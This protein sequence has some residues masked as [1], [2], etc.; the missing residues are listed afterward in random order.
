MVVLIILPGVL[1]APGIS[2]AGFDPVEVDARTVAWPTI[3]R[4]ALEAG[5]FPPVYQPVTEGELADLLAG[6]MDEAMSGQAE[7]FADNA[8][9]ARLEFWLDRYLRG[10]GGRSWHGCDC[11]VHPPQVRLTG[12]ALAGFT[13]LGTTFDREAGLGWSPGW[14][15]TLE[16]ALDFSAGP[17]WISV[18]GRL[19]GQ[20]APAGVDFSGAGGD[21]S[22]LTWPDWSIPTGKNQVRAARLQG[23]SWSLEAPRAVAGVTL[24]HWSLSAGWAPR[25]TGPGLTGALAFDRSGASIPAVTARRTRKFIWGSRFLNFFAPDELLLTTGVLSERLV[26]YQD[27]EEQLYE[28]TAHPWFFQWLIGWRVTPWFRA[29]FTHAAM[30]APREGT[31]WGDVLQINFPIKGTTWSETTHGPV[32]D[33]IFSA[34]FEG[35]WRHAPWPILPAAAGRLFWDYAGTDYLPSG[36]GGVVPRISVPASVI[37]IE[38]VDPDWDLA[39]EYSE[40]VHE[41]VLWYSNSGFPEGYSQ[42]GW[43][44]GHGL[45]GSGESDLRRGPGQAP[46]LGGAAG[47]A[48]AAGDLGDG[49][50]D[51]GTG[52]QTT[53][54]LSVKNLPS[55]AQSEGPPSSPLLWEI[56]AEWNREKADPVAGPGD[57]KDWWRVYCRF[58]I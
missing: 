54:A 13:D 48:R 16:P 52:R 51:P 17:W 44:M 33:R 18:T 5:V 11:K 53:V 15:A 19:T 31:L 47:A 43:L 3:R 29:T 9:F 1:A 34:Q 41:D 50:P 35:R 20:V 32:T 30:A 57:Q 42:D 49:Q 26:R 58:G 36:P 25:T 28:K 24:G 56:T 37:G 12:R 55:G 22:P 7:A 4:L 27:A 39:F 40:L 45:G 8:E 46:R 21:Q 38:L 6:A 10:G 2:F 23:D 14:N